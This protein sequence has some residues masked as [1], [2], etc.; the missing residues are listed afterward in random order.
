MSVDGLVYLS[1]GVI[2]VD[3]KEIFLIWDA[4]KGYLCSRIVARDFGARS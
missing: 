3:L 4:A 2:I 1:N